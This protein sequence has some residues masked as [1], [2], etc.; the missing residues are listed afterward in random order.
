MEKYIKLKQKIE[1]YEKRAKDLFVAA[2]NCK[3][4]ILYDHWSTCLVSIK[5]ENG[6]KL[7]IDDAVAYGRELNRR[8]DRLR[9]LTKAIAAAI[10]ECKVEPKDCSAFIRCIARKLSIPFFSDPEGKYT[11][12]QMY[13]FLLEEVKKEGGE[14]CGLREEEVQ[15]KADDGRFIVGIAHSASDLHGHIVIALPSFFLE[16][17]PGAIHADNRSIPCVLDG[18]RAPREVSFA[19]I[20][21]FGNDDGVTA[22]IWGY[23]KV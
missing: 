9:T 6:R 13:D 16:P 20:N 21:L 2:G 19:P 7:T 1:E 8:V 11:A 3:N 10:E 17:K 14:W 5:S 15:D 23:Y 12:N 22:P 4:H 18:Q